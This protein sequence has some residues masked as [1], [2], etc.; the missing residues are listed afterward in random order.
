MEGFD[1]LSNDVAKFKM[2]D[3]TSESV[4]KSATDDGGG[5]S[6]LFPTPYP[7]VMTLNMGGRKFQTQS[8]TLRHGS[9]VFRGQLFEKHTWARRL[10]LPVPIGYFSRP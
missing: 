7:P 5:S 9:G 2:N 10:F 6:L 8:S 4:S 3:Y 1:I